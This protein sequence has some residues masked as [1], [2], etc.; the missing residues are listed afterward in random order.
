MHI[1]GNLFT[2]GPSAIV[3]NFNTGERDV[4][5]R[6]ART[7]HDKEGSMCGGSD[8]PFIYADDPLIITPSALIIS[9]DDGVDIVD[10]DTNHPI[11]YVVW[12]GM[13]GGVYMTSP[14]GCYLSHSERPL[15]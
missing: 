15:I 14:R 7:R 4:A 5:V 12:E 6:I 3:I 2:L 10:T 9:G 13:D 1:I 11:D 8:T